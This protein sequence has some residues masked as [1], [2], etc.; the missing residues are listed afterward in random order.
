[1]RIEQL[2]E[3]LLFE[4]FNQL[5]S[6]FNE[7]YHDALLRDSN[8]EDLMVDVIMTTKKLDRNFENPVE[9]FAFLV[10]NNQPIVEED[11]GSGD[12]QLKDV[13]FWV[14]QFSQSKGV[15]RA[16]F[17][18]SKFLRVVNESAKLFVEK[19]EFRENKDNFDILHRG[20]NWILFEPHHK[21]ASCNLGTNTKWCISSRSENHFDHY[22][23][24][25]DVYIIH[26]RNDKYSIIVQNGNIIEVQDSDNDRKQQHFDVHREFLE[27]LEKDGVDLEILFDALNLDIERYSQPFY[28]F[29]ETRILEEPN[30]METKDQFEINEYTLDG[31]LGA[32]DD[33]LGV[34]EHSEF[35]ITFLTI[36]T[37]DQDGDKLGTYFVVKDKP[38][39]RF[40]STLFWTIMD[41]VEDDGVMEN[42][43]RMDDMLRNMLMGEL[44]E[45]FTDEG[46]DTTNIETSGGEILRAALGEYD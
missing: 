10:R 32:F 39:N 11:G 18:T 38:N 16:A 31:I 46:F 37:F 30:S 40:F 45:A 9:I 42:P 1:M 5:K 43:V 2:L 7:V 25:S 35:E 20:D 17:L 12:P 19:K 44:R 4:N 22:S 41:K 27:V 34:N 29:Y 21:A 13:N 15:A 6:L 36:D 23:Y 24:R 8:V 14:S 33:L 26:T 3:Q 28:T